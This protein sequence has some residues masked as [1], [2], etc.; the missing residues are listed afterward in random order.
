SSKL[1]FDRRLVD[2]RPHVLD[3]AVLEFIENILPKRDLATVHRQVEEVG[4]R[5]DLEAESAR[6]T[7]WLYDQQLDVEMQIGYL[8]IV[9][10]QHRPVAGDSQALAI[11]LDV[12][13]NELG[14]M[15]P[16]L[17]VQALQVIAVEGLEIGAF[18][19]NSIL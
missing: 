2:H 14:K 4:F 17:L 13:M 5:G 16:V 9:A 8:L 3:L 19:D 7:G 10:F 18:H 15:I 1:S 6:D 12:V 11:V